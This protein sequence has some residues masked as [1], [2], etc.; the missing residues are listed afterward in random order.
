[1]KKSPFVYILLIISFLSNG[2]SIPLLHAQEISLPAVGAMVHLSAEFI[3]AHLSG[4]TIHPENGLQFDFL[5][6]KGEENLEGPQKKE[7]YNKLIKYFLASLATPDEDQWVNLSPYEKDRII[8][9]D[10]GKT[11]MGRDLLA[12]DYIL[13]QITASLIYPE[14]KLGQE[15]WSKVFAMAQTQFGSTDIPVNTFNKV[16]IVPDE[17]VVY[18]SGQSA[19]ILKSHLKVMLEE[20]YL[21]LNKHAGVSTMPQ[22]KKDVSKLSS[23]I[24]REIVLPEIEKEVNEGK[25]FALLR[26]IY[27]SMILATWFKK[28]LRES[29]LGK[30]YVDRSKVK[31]IEQDPK[32]NEEIYQQYLQAFK[33]GVYSFIKDDFDKYSQQIIPR[34]YFSGGIINTLLPPHG[35]TQLKPVLKIVNAQSAPP[36]MLNDLAMK[37]VSGDLLKVTVDLKEKRLPDRAM[38]SFFDADQLVTNYLDATPEGLEFTDAVKNKKIDIGTSAKILTYIVIERSLEQ[39]DIDLTYDNPEVLAKLVEE[40]KDNHVWLEKMD[41]ILQRDSAMISALIRVKDRLASLMATSVK[42]DDFFEFDQEG[43]YKSLKTNELGQP[44]FNYRVAKELARRWVIGNDESAKQLLFEAAHDSYGINIAY[45]AVNVFQ[46]QKNKNEIHGSLFET[47]KLI[48][49]AVRARRNV[50]SIALVDKDIKELVNILTAV[51]AQGFRPSNLSSIYDDKEMQGLSQEEREVR[52]EHNLSEAVRQAALSRAQQDEMRKLYKNLERLHFYQMPMMF[53]DL[54][55]M[56]TGEIEFYKKSIEEVYSPLNIALVMIME[57][58][59]DLQDQSSP[60]Q[61]GQNLEF[62]RQTLRKIDEQVIRQAQKVGDKLFYIYP[63]AEEWLAF[64]MFSFYP[65]QNERIEKMIEERPNLENTDLPG[66]QNLFIRRV[67]ALGEI[68]SKGA[69]LLVGANGMHLRTVLP[70]QAQQIRN[71]LE[72]LDFPSQIILLPSLLGGIIR[73]EYASQKSDLTDALLNGLVFEHE[74]YDNVITRILRTVPKDILQKIKD[75]VRQK[76]IFRRAL[77][78]KGGNDVMGSLETLSLMSYKKALSFFELFRPGFPSSKAYFNQW[79]SDKRLQIGEFRYMEEYG[80]LDQRVSHNIMVLGNKL[81]VTDEAMSDRSKFIAGMI[82]DFVIFSAVGAGMTYSI[83][84]FTRPQ[85]SL[86]ESQPSAVTPPSSAQS[87]ATSSKSDSRKVSL[88]PDLNDSAMS[89]DAGDGIKPVAP[90]SKIQSQLPQKQQEQKSETGKG[91]DKAFQGKDVVQI[92]SQGKIFS[93]LQHLLGSLSQKDLGTVNQKLQEQGLQL[94]AE[95]SGEHLRGYGDV[96]VPFIHDNQLDKITYRE[97]LRKNV[98]VYRIEQNLTSSQITEDA[99]NLKGSPLVMDSAMEVNFNKGGID[100][101]SASFNLKIKRDS[102]GVPLSM[103]QQDLSHI[104]IEGLVP[105]IIQIKPITHL[106]M[107]SELKEDQTIQT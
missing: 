4:I 45:Q 41:Q 106:P 10:F 55:R 104:N 18:Q 53:H 71:N 9:E 33:K 86:E 59:L 7:E 44:L 8:K 35:A 21:S 85:G 47:A 91:Q 101:N 3:P 76:D 94:I 48:L 82:V 107:L 88:N 63:S 27:S 19:F 56:P 37:A 61:K 93:I 96:P 28:S 46:T 23:T 83:V 68:S 1:M 75:V 100:F 78:I 98:K 15:F 65:H 72:E 102:N 12:Q 34:K 92:S 40:R 62:I 52:F 32:A 90:V 99:Q 36:Q 69:A 89:S 30:I 97:I 57:S 51:D 70:P 16:W 22:G 39:D 25:N 50:S 14:S 2:I 74:Q 95:S 43:Q 77:D 6:N 31:G 84:E 58:L 105:V 29:L 5:V 13:K 38:M 81:G 79:R 60:D 20:D 87:T 67:I 73:A 42:L 17:A 26:Q 103:A 54:V 80:A 11:E 64:S 66:Y 49:D 24:V